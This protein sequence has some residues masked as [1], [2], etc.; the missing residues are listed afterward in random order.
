MFT[1]ATISVYIWLIKISP[2]QSEVHRVGAVME[3]AV[4]EGVGWLDFAGGWL[5][6]GTWTTEPITF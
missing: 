3:K 5:R 1:F 4:C 6:G 2:V